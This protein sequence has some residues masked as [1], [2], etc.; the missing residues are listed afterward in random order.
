VIIDSSAILAIALREPD[1]LRML[2]AIIEAPM[3]KISAANGLE[4]SLVVDGKKETTAA[5]DFDEL[6]DRL[7]IKIVEVS[8]EQAVIAREAHRRFGRGHHPAK[9]N[10]GDCFAYALARATGEPL[11]FKGHDFSQTDVEPALRD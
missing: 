8:P 6:M 5:A 3:C 1:E 7:K 11:L 10:Y 4:I 2:T 9:L